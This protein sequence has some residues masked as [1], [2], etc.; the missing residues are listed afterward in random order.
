MAKSV[1][2]I[3]ILEDDFDLARGW[4]IA[5]QKNGHEVTCSYTS[6][7]AITHADHEKFD[8]YIVDLKIDID[9]EAMADSGVKLLGH[10]S[11]IF[12]NAEIPHRVIGV[13]GL[14][15]SDDDSQTRHAFRMFEVRNFLPK[16]FDAATLVT[17]VE[18]CLSELQR[19]ES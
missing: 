9:V 17:T 13:S 14:A 12:P 11:R 8:I 1:S 2:N 4:R 6:S 15:I 16:P 18:K 5:L 19:F 3:L 10:L 7:E